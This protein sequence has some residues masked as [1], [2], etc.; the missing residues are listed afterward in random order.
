MRTPASTA[1]CLLEIVHSGESQHLS[2]I[3]NQGCTP[4]I[5]Q[6]RRRFFLSLRR[7]EYRDV[8]ATDEPVMKG[9]P[10]DTQMT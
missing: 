7:G 10:D 4:S 5:Q 9:W 6:N 1:L 2:T 3:Q 8:R